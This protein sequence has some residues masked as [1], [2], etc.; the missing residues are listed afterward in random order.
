MPA[1]MN[2]VTSAS[3]ITIIRD[4]LVNE[5]STPPI[6]ILTISPILN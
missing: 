1:I 6:S 3:T 2:T 4:E 5:M